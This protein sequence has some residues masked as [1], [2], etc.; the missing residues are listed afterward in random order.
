MNPF[1]QYQWIELSLIVVPLCRR[2]NEMTNAKYKTKQEPLEVTTDG[3]KVTLTARISAT[4]DGSP[5]RIEY[6]FKI[7]EGKIISLRI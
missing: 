2:W 7:K 5:A 1:C 3:D 6:H 4:F